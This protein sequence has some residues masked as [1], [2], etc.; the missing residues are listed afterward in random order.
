[1]ENDNIKTSSSIQCKYYHKENAEESRCIMDSTVGFC[2]VENG[3]ECKVRAT[4]IIQEIFSRK[5]K[6]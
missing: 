2:I 3:F 1:M 6:G 5:I 4:E